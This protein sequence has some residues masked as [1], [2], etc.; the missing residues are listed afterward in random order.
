MRPKDRTRGFLVYHRPGD[1]RERHAAEFLWALRSPQT[2][3]ARLVAHRSKAR[4]GDVLVLGKIF[5]IAF[6]RQD[7]LLDKG[8]RA[9]AKVFELGRKRE[10]HGRAFRSC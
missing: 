9:Q 2:G 5:R 4:V 3:F 10:I 8:A 7:V 1:D 6:E